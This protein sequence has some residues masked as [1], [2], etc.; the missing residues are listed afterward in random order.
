[1]K[2][3]QQATGANNLLDALIETLRLKNDAALARSLEVAP[4]VLSKIRHGK[5]PVG[6]SMLI[7]MHESSELPIKELRA[8]MGDQA[9][10]F[11]ETYGAQKAA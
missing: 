4:P 5:L 3:T 9:R 11:H 8:L 2:N 7:R 6:A 1:M 10:R